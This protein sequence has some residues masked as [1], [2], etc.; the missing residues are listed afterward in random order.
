[1]SYTK[2]E[3]IETALTELGLA[4]Y[5]F[6]IMPDQFRAALTR[7]DM[8]MADWYAKGIDVGYAQPIV[9]N[10]S[11]LSD[12]S[13]IDSAAWEAVVLQLAI[14]IAPSFGKTPSSSTR[15]NATNAMNTVFSTYSGTIERTASVLPAGAGNKSYDQPFISGD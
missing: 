15:I 7:L 12:D 4:V 2:R 5:S 8:M 9:P 11:E 3:L 14:R 1:M 10:D 6:D 13:E